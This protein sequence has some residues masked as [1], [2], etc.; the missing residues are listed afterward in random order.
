MYS[1]DNIKTGTTTPW[2][3]Q[4]IEEYNDDGQLTLLSKE[5]FHHEE[6]D[7]TFDYRYAI[8]AIDMRAAVGEGDT[9]CIQLYLVPE[10]KD[11]CEASLRK[12]A[13]SYGWEKESRE[14][15]LQQM[16]PQDAIENG[17]GVLVGRDIVA[18]DTSVYEDGFY[19][20]LDNGNAVEKI[21]AAASIVAFY[22]ATRGF[23]LDSF[24]NR[25]GTTGWD[26]LNECLHGK[27]MIQAGLD[28]LRKQKEAEEE[29]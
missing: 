22:D 14:S 6:P 3:E 28:R 4:F 15:I 27:D 21:N 26:V 25:V 1:F 12:A 13:V 5:T 23:V 19:D 16:R 20:I 17:Y 8:T 2:Q 7:L 24:Q 11:W 9:I 18:Y 10:P 29:K